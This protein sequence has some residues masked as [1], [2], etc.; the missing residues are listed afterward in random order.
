MA[1]SGPA[2]GN[3]GAVS[4]DAVALSLIAGNQRAPLSGYAALRLL[5]A[6]QS[7]GPRR[8]VS[9]LISKFAVRKSFEKPR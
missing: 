6:L 7:A 8:L 9:H 3:A 4:S 1:E 5:S 2:P